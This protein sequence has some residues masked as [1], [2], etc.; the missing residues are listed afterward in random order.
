MSDV[1][2]LQNHDQCYFNKRGEWADGHDASGL[3]QT[4]YKDEA[5]NQ[6]LELTVRH[7]EL[8]ITIV[9]CQ[10]DA[11]GRPQLM[12]PSGTT[13]EHLPPAQESLSQLASTDTSAP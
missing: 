9:K 1:F 6:K 10:L 7:A 11:K 13:E 8:R 3:Y 5:L 4:P 2:I 12:S